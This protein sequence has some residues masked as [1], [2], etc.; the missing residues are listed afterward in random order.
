M[1]TRCGQC[2][3]IILHSGICCSVRLMAAMVSSSASRR[4][5][6]SPLGT[7]GAQE[8]GEAAERSRTAKKNAVNERCNVNETHFERS[9]P[10]K[11]ASDIRQNAGLSL[12]P[13]S[14]LVPELGAHDRIPELV[15][16]LGVSCLF[17]EAQGVRFGSR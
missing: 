3:L 12:Q 10:P 7:A 2:T 13:Q 5:N 1:T 16:P 9:V 17:L 4:G 6:K 15:R 14:R 11:S 8:Y